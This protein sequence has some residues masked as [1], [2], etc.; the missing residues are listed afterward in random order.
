MER[1]FECEID[2]PL[3]D[4]SDIRQRLQRAFPSM[5]WEEGDSS[6]DKIRVWGENPELFIGV[7]RYES[8]GSFRLRIYLRTPETSSGD[9]E[10]LAIRDKV[11]LALRA[12]KV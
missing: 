10:H 9:G 2:I 12:T 7:Y 6:W 5:K 8:P 11:L 4:E 1:K 3:A